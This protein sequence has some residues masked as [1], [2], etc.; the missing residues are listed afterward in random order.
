MRF[1]LA[2][3]KGKQSVSEE[4]IR[5]VI[6]DGAREAGFDPLEAPGF[7]DGLADAL[8]AHRRFAGMQRVV[9]PRTVRHRDLARELRH[10]LDAG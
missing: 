10:R 1:Y 9:L 8:R 7:V 2:P 5:G 4:P 3:R 6:V